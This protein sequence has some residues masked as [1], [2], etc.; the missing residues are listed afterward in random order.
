MNLIFRLYCFFAGLAVASWRSDV[1]NRDGGSLDLIRLVSRTNSRPSSPEKSAS[2]SRSKPLVVQTLDRFNLPVASSLRRESPPCGDGPSSSSSQ[3]L[4]K[5]IT[6]PPLGNLRISSDLPVP[7]K[8]ATQI[9]GKSLNL[10]TAPRR[11]SITQYPK[12]V[13]RPGAQSLAKSVELRRSSAIDSLQPDPLTHL[14]DISKGKHSALAIAKGPAYIEAAVLGK[15]STVKLVMP[16]RTGVLSIAHDQKT[17]WATGKTGEK[18]SV[19]AAAIG[20]GVVANVAAS[21]H[22]KGFIKTYGPDGH[23]THTKIGPG[24]QEDQQ[25]EALNPAKAELAT[26]VAIDGRG[27]ATAGGLKLGPEQVPGSKYAPKR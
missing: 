3:V 15:P 14:N 2:S 27:R 6:T 19:V 9:G 10:A 26:T 13:I 7:H 24:K 1:S 5:P 12:R 17:V 21:Y 23:E 18:G 4:K 16:G 20:E 22:G 25:W 11:S 8:Q